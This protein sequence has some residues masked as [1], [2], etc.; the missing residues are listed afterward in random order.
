MSAF[1]IL[2]MITFLPLAGALIILIARASVGAQ[3]AATV[4]SAALLV[5]LATFGLSVW[6][7]TEFDPSL[8]GY[9][10]VEEAAWFT[11]VS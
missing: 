2:S 9:Q 8:S 11:G 3:S 10:L 7:I 6:A 5:T 4:R 1:P